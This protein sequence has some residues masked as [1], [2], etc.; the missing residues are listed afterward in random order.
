MFVSGV[1]AGPARDGEPAGSAPPRRPGKRGDELAHVQ[2]EVGSGDAATGGAS[3]LPPIAHSAGPAYGRAPRRPR[4]P[5][6]RAPHSS[7]QRTLNLSAVLYSPEP[8]ELPARTFQVSHT[9]L[10]RALLAFQESRVA[11]VFFSRSLLPL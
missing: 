2:G 5:N 10:G 8:A 1:A 7:R 11:P 9:P 3:R 4:A 6:G